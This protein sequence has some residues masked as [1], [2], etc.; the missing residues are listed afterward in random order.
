MVFAA[1]FL[2]VVAHLSGWH[3]D[4]IAAGALDDFDVADYKLIVHRHRAKSF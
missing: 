3:C 1:A 4:E 2:T